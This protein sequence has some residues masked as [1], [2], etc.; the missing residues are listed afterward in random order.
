MVRALTGRGV[1]VRLVP[2]D[3]AVEPAAGNSADASRS[4]R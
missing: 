2:A 1:D 3:G 4:Y